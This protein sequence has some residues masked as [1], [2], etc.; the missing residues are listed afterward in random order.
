MTDAQAAAFMHNTIRDAYDKVAFPI[1]LMWS[2]L[3]IL[4]SFLIPSPQTSTIS[5]Q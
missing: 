4:I 3:K 1:N 2:T 5:R